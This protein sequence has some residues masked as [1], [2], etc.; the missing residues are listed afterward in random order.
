[1][2]K[3]ACLIILLSLAAPANA[4][5]KYPTL[6]WKISGNGL[7][8]PSFLYGTMHVSNRVAYYLSEQFFAAL[9]SADVVGLETNPGEWLDNMER[10]GELAEFTNVRETGQ[11]NFYKTAFTISYPERRL[12]Q[13]II[14]YDPDIINGLLY[15]QNTAHENFEESTYIDLFI[16]QSAS[17][18]NKRVISLENFAQSE[19]KARLSAIPDEDRNADTQSG[20][21][22]SNAQKIEDAYRD[23]NLDMIDSLSKLGT[24]K[25]MQRFLINERNVFFVHTIDSVLK[26]ESLFSGV[27]AAHLPGDKGVIELLRKKGYTVEPVTP[28]VSKKSHNTREE[29]DLQVKPV[30]FQKQFAGDS[31]F[32]VSLPGKLYP[33]L[34]TGN[35]KYF[36]HPDM[37]NGNFYTVVRLKH[38]GPLFGITSAQMLLRMDS[39]LFEHIPGKI[40]TRKDISTANGIKGIEVIN[41]TRGGDQQHYQ[42]FFTDLEIMM[43]KLGGKGDYAS[44]NDARQFF[45]SIQFIQKPAHE[46]EYSPAT[47]G[48]SV[49]L[50]SNY[51]YVKRNGGAV[52]ELV[53][54]LFAYNKGKEEAFGVNQAIYNDFTYLE[55]D[56]FELHQFAKHILE[57]Y[58]FKG[59]AAP[60]KQELG[61][62]CIRFTGKS[63]HANLYGKLYIKGVHY[64]FVYHL[65]QKESGF[66]N[67][68]FNSFRL[69]DFN[70]INPLKEVTDKDFY[71]KVTDE[72]TENA[73]SRFNEAYVQAYEATRTKKDS[74]KVNYDFRTATKYYY[75]PSSNEYINITYEKYNDYDYREL[76]QM[77]EKIAAALGHNSS[78]MVTG[79]T[80]SAANGIH[81]FR[82]ILKDTATVRAIA[83]KVMFRNG[84][85]YEIS[86][87]YDTTLGL[88]GWAKSFMETFEPADSV[89][90]KDIFKYKFQDLLNDLASSDSVLR[91]E[92][93]NSIAG[94]VSMHKIYAG[95]FL[96]FISGPSI[97][98]VS[99]NSRAHLF[100]NGGTL[101]N[102]G[103]IEPYKKLYRQYTDSFYLQLCLLKGLACLKTQN[104][105]NAFQNL[106]LAETPLVGDESTVADVFAL[107]HDS[108][109]LC[110]KFFPQMLVLAKY[111]EY[112]NPMYML[113]AELVHQKL[114]SAQK[115]RVYR[116][117]ILADANLA[118]KRYSP[119]AA[120]MSNAEETDFTE[121]SVREMAELIKG[122]LDA[123]ANNN[124]YRNSRYLKSIEATSRPSLV[125][126][127]W[128]LSPF[129]K[130]DE[131]SRQFISKLSKIKTQNILMPVALD[132]LQREIKLNDTLVPYYCSNKFTR[133]YFYSEL[134]KEGLTSKF[135]KRYLSQV[136]LNES[137]L[138]SQKQLSSIY[139]NDG[140]RSEDSLVLVKELPAKNKYQAGTMYIYSSSHAKTDGE[141]WSALFVSNHEK[142]VT[143]RIE[144]VNTAYYTDHLK[145]EKENIN[146][147]LDQFYLQFRKRAASGAPY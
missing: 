86:V 40:L 27:G 124:F 57:N 137:V 96:K 135:D 123:L 15:R 68:F 146:E 92:A 70:Y 142:G 108:L 32:S 12:L 16:F 75:S 97:N 83:V 14:S 91:R 90:G 82:Y 43:F 69:T 112:R 94:S 119:A 51:N 66:D 63:E 8:K 31:A 59:S 6:L 99:E 128:V 36:I 131:K 60:V 58:G 127:A 74:V 138:S 38:N 122:N 28:K 17:K 116:E 130:T 110:R 106:L 93:G 18:L 107:L 143:A 25:N 3:L 67:G 115:Y 109:P 118:L 145:T 114:L 46:V 147:L 89:I 30:K 98:N 84:I 2:K 29:L 54:E 4:Q 111:E 34:N 85:M 62:P 101:Q 117:Q 13:G 80:S 45:N 64:Y 140:K 136:Q 134:E 76:G 47:G 100:V 44:S 103:I 26:K 7:K 24:S 48:F 79:R 141:Q 10:T 22:Y 95:D 71:F 33:I 1:M 56:T 132:L 144:L 37:V 61:F 50:P 55:E 35:L 88:R 73:L 41:Q 113:L 121:K 77:D 39:L 5:K 126:Y 20:T 104:A 19:I 11:R 87:P 9:K 53:E 52:S 65:S 21:Y 102:E 42:I 129:Y 23:G 78:A 139:R 105:Y 49:R 81:T 120:R 133:A 125:N 72:V